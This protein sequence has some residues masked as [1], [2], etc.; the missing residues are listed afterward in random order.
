MTHTIKRS[1]SYRQMVQIFL[2]TG[3]LSF[4]GWSTTALLLEKE[5]VNKRKILSAQQLKAATAYAQIL[6]GATQVA[7]I[8]NVGYQ[9]RGIKGSLVATVSYLLPAVSLIM[10]F[11]VL[12]FHYASGVNITKYLDGLTAALGGVILANSYRIGSK[13]VNHPALWALVGL[14]FVAQYWLHVNALIIIVVFGLAGLTY[15][16]FHRYLDNRRGAQ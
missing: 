14:A 8:S 7:I 9:L 1:I 13:H 3:S 16:Y 12:Y 4:G 11:A 2:R 10:V 5:L 6:P 15:C